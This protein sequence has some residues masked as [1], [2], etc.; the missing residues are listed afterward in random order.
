MRGATHADGAASL[1]LTGMKVP[2]D[3]QHSHGVRHSDE[4]LTG[5]R[6]SSARTSAA[7]AR[8]SPRQRRRRERVGFSD[9]GAIRVAKELVLKQSCTRY[10]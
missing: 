5:R 9:G 2:H 7:S 1:G 8:A 3:A 6:A 10:Y 4:V